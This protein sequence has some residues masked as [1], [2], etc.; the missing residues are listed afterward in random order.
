MRRVR[1]V[2]L[3]PVAL[4]PTLVATATPAP[5]QDKPRAGGEPIFVVPSEPPSYD[6]HPDETFGVIRPLAPHSSKV[7]G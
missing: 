4:A 3:R 7:H 2:V 6:A 5:A 1:F